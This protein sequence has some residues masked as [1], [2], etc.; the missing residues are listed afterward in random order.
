MCHNCCFCW[1]TSICPN[2][3]QINYNKLYCTVV[4]KHTLCYTVLLYT[5][6]NY[7]FK[8][9]TKKVRWATFGNQASCSMRLIRKQLGCILPS[10]FFSCVLCCLLFS[11]NS[12]LH[13]R[14]MTRPNGCRESCSGVNWSVSAR[15]KPADGDTCRCLCQQRPVLERNAEVRLQDIFVC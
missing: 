12:S 5:N 13:Q 11:F 15:L 1:C 14:F 6:I 8:C 9:K 10:L 7:V 2:K 3:L 4:H